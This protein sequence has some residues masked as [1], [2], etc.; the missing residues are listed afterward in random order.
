MDTVNDLYYKKIY[1]VKII[2]IESG[3]IR[4]KFAY[5]PELAAC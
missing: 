5:M 2:K 3:K 1:L 4:S